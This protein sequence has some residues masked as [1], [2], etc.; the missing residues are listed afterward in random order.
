[1]EP[2]TEH[3][4]AWWCS[5]HHWPMLWCVCQPVQQCNSCCHSIHRNLP[6]SMFY[7]HAGFT[8]IVVCGAELYTS[9]CAYM[10]AAWWEGK[11]GVPAVIRMLAIS[12]TGNF[13]GCAL[14]AG[15]LKASM[16]YDHYDY[17]LKAIARDKVS[18][19]W[20]A[21][22]VKGIFAN[23]LVSWQAWCMHEWLLPVCAIWFCPVRDPEVT[24]AGQPFCMHRS[25]QMGQSGCMQVRRWLG[26]P[27]PVLT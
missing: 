4:Y 3:T 8:T 9:L 15:L 7:S 16:I 22:F 2:Y 18:H 11:V 21:T 5:F 20:G 17:T 12:W 6:C 24:Q 10:T 19:P 1:M 13:I 27:A 26:S 25:N 14:M 23:W